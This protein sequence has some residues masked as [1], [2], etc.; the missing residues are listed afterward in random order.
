[1]RPTCSRISLSKPKGAL[2]AS[3]I[4]EVLVPVDDQNLHCRFTKVIAAAWTSE[5]QI[6]GI[7]ESVEST[8]NQSAI[9]GNRN[10]RFQ[11]GKALPLMTALVK[12]CPTS[13]LTPR[14]VWHA[15]RQRADIGQPLTKPALRLVRIAA[16]NLPLETLANE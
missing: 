7:R 10:V 8:P 9:R 5:C 14:R 3:R 11:A 4:I 1:M 2:L 12:G 15:Q 13:A 6:V 16:D